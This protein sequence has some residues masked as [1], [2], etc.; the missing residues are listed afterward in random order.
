MPSWPVTLPAF[1]SMDDLKETP[2]DKTIRSSMDEG[3]AKTRFKTNAEPDTLT[4][5][6]VLTSAEITD[7]ETFYNDTLTGGALTFTDTHPRL[8]TTKTFRFVKPPEF[9]NIGG[10]V[11]KALVELEVV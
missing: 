9:V 11:W 3:P 10:P 1:S 5:S 6:V 4:F 2:G 8:A 7:L